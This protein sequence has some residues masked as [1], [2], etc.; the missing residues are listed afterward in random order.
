MQ[1]NTKIQMKQTN[2][3]LSIKILTFCAVVG[4]TLQAYSQ[5]TA[6]PTVPSSSS[7][8][9][10]NFLYDSS[11]I[12]ANIS[13]I[14]Y[15]ESWGGWASAADYSI[16]PTVLGYHTVSY[17]GI[18][19]EGNPQDV[20]GFVYLHVDV[21]TPNGNCFALALIDTS[22]GKRA[23]VTYTTASGVIVPNTWLHLDIPI[24]S[25][26]AANATLNLHHINQMG[27]IA[28]NAGETPGADYYL[29]NLY[30]Y[31]PPPTPLNASITS[32]TNGATV[33]NFLTINA[34]AGV[35]PGT[36]TN[37]SFYDGAAFLGMATNA[38]Y[39]YYA[40][41]GLAAGAHSLT[42]VAMASGGTSATSSVVN[43][44]VTNQLVGAYE[45]F[46]Y[47]A[48]SFA[49]GTAATGSGFTGN[50]SLSGSGTINAAGLGYSNLLAANKSFQQS[51]A[52][53]RDSVSL[54]TPLSSGTVY[55]SYLYD[56]V[57]NNGG[58]T[59]GLYLPGTGSS[60]LFVGVTAPYSG[61]AGSLGLASVTTA[62]SGAT[63]AA[64]LSGAMQMNGALVYN[65]TNLIVLRIDFNTSGANDTVS[66]WLNPP[67][68]TNAPGV[69]ANL[70]Y[71]GYDV[72]TITGIGFNLQGGG[73]NNIFD[74]IRVG[75]SYGSVVSAPNPTVATTVA[76]STN[77][78]STVSWSAYSTNVYQPQSSPD[79]STWSDLGSQINGNSVT[80]IVDPANAAYYQVL[81][82]YPVT[83]EVVANGGFDYDTGLT[84][85]TAQNWNSVQS[86]PPVWINTDGHTALGCMDL[87]VTNTTATPNGAEIQ[88]NTI[89]QGNPVTPGESYNFSFWAKQISSGPSYVQNYAV[90]WLNGPAYISQ[91]SASFSGGS[92]T[93]AQITANGLVAP[94]G[95]TTALIQIIGNT[96]AVLGGYGEVLIDD[97]SLSDTALTGGPNILAPTVQQNM[98]FTATVQTNGIAAGDAT[99]T[100]TFKT[101]SVQLSMNTVVSGVASSAGTS[102]NPPY[103][104]TAIYSGD[105]TYLG[106]TG[107]LTVGGTG[108]SGPGTITNSVSGNT[109]T[110]TWPAGQG[111]RLVGQTNS[112]S[113]GLNPSPSAWFAVPGGSDGSNSLPFNRANPAVFYKLVSP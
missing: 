6:A 10:S 5:P 46:N 75:T 52:G 72:G 60:S 104:A 49:N 19:F 2:T 22:T 58:N 50:W 105:G 89:L 81:E 110:L 43:I 26:A 28:N 7:M 95:A 71:N 99:G 31:S 16:P 15:Y 84:P 92:G 33:G 30:F 55:I 102:I 107:T 112:M 97:V 61:S 62:S 113:I 69:A 82:Y 54:A 78:A 45:P 41:S 14:N 76:V 20:S 93:W 77:L 37:V 4:G 85:D 40:S 106:S 9:A 35:Y 27:I 1:P 94:A 47:T 39:S 3:K 98:T 42:A 91:A 56:Q 74:E 18:G 38:P 68:G 21:Y 24:S 90:Q 111:W 25:Y 23:D 80:S 48:G 8:S 11:G 100:V 13:G 66:L 83:T 64:L 36:V 63:G 70:T 44:T 87:A 86:Q 73:Q 108:P 32:P 67:A 96:G 101:N 103:T 59:C 51:P 53:Q 88:Q 109:L 17:G 57:G 65:T 79:G 12:Y 34:S 29:D